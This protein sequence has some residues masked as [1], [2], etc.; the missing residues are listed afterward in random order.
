MR[1]SMV[2]RL[3]KQ[4][5][6]KI[7]GLL[8][9]IEEDFGDEQGRQFSKNYNALELPSVISS[10]VEFLHPHLT[11]Y[12]IAIYWYLFDK[13]IVKTGEQ[14]ARASTRGMSSTAKSA[15]G[16]SDDLSYG[17]IKKTLDALKEKEAISIVPCKKNLR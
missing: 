8:S 4:K 10:I 5:L 17:V 7:R 12:Q 11:P 3:M 16:K 14:Y 6:K 13:S 9:Q 2:C 15:S 1:K